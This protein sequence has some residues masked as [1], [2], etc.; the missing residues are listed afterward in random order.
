MKGLNPRNQYL[1]PFCPKSEY[2]HQN[3]NF[4]PQ[5]SAKLIDVTHILPID[6]MRKQ[7]FIALMTSATSSI[8]TIFRYERVKSEESEYISI[9][10]WIRI[11]PSKWELW[12]TTLSKIDWCDPCLSFSFKCEN[13]KFFA[14]MTSDTSSIWTTFRYEKVNSEASKFIANLSWIRILPSK[15]ELS[16]TKFSKQLCFVVLLETCLK[17]WAMLWWGETK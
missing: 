6:F 17:V 4:H 15:W 13:K 16:P 11:L 5:H 1:L 2:Y 7:R 3:G 10:S 12:P 8:W 14:L 9:L